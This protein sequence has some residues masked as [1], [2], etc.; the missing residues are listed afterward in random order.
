[1]LIESIILGGSFLFAGIP[2]MAIG[3]AICWCVYILH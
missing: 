1:M 3:V 2:G